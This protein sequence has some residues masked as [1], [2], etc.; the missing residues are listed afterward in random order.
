MQG[1]QAEPNRRK[2]RIE[3]NRK[4]VI[5]TIASMLVYSTS[6]ILVVSIQLS[7]SSPAV[8]YESLLL[9]NPHVWSR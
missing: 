8:S 6:S 5:D 7:F 2:D 4:D 9:P 3:R 1:P